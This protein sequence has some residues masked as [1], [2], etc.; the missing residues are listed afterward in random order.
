MRPLTNNELEPCYSCPKGCRVF[1]DIGEYETVVCQC[2]EKVN[3][4]CDC[5]EARADLQTLRRS[6]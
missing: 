5:A 3:G 4:V 6:C 1:H 2:D